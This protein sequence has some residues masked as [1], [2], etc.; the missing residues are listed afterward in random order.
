MTFA[1][2][3]A[4]MN[5]ILVNGTIIEHGNTFRYLGNEITTQGEVDVT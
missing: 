4:I 5:E 1:G 3:D 2:K